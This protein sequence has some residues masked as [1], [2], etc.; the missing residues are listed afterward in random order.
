MGPAQLADVLRHLPI[1][2]DPNLLVGLENRDDA[3]VYLLSSDIALVQTVDFFTPIV[4][5][6]YAYGQIA[7]ANALSDVYAMGG[8]PVTVL[9]IACFDPKAAPPEVWAEVLKGAYDKTVESGAVVAGGHSVEDDE[10]KFG[11]AVTGVVDPNKMFANTAARPG[12]GIYLSKPLG[13]GILTT[14]AKWDQCT[15]EEL[16]AGI[17]T[18]SKLNRD[19]AELGVRHGVQCATDITGFGLAGHLYNVARAS[20][21][22]IEIDSSALPLLPGI[23]RLAEEGNTTGG[24][25]KNEDFI[26]EAISFALDVPQWL[27]DVVLDPQTSGGLALFSQTPIPGLPK[28]G[29]VSEGLAS[30]RVR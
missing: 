5:D 4:D 24:A 15:A 26:G 13:T 29:V 20:G 27:R 7:A 6:P 8:K 21:V 1:S 28:I 16:L 10:P 23:Q 3:G 19:A 12:D 11:L 9:N 18:M 25:K 2:T 14:A 30:I 17:E 22:A